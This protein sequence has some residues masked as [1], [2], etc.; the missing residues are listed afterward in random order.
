MSVLDSVYV[1]LFGMSVVFVVLLGLSML[2]RL[3]TALVK[4]MVKK[5]PE[6]AAG[7]PNASQQASAEEPEPLRLI[8]VDERTAAMVMAIVCD[9]M[10][11]QPEELQFKYI[12]KISSNK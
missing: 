12:R 1:G 3:Q 6:K 10:K 8:D 7:E 4:R 9:D 5:R 11:A 2:L